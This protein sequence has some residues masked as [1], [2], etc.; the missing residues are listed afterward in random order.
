[1]SVPEAF[2][3]QKVVAPLRVPPTLIPAMVLYATLTVLVA[4]LLMPLNPKEPPAALFTTTMLLFTE[5]LPMVFPWP[6]AP[7]V[8]LDVPVTTIPVTMGNPA[9]AP[10]EVTLMFWITFPLIVLENPT[11]VLKLI[12]V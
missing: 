4:L 3:M 1:M 5:V 8:K 9:L 10:V 2:L 6:D 11:E 7:T 12:P